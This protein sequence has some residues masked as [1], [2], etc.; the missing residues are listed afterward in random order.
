MRRDSTA[1]ILAIVGL[2]L[3]EPARGF[4]ASDSEPVVLITTG[5]HTV[6]T[7]LDYLGFAVA[8]GALVLIASN[9]V[10]LWKARRFPVLAG[11]SAADMAAATARFRI[12]P[13]ALLACAILMVTLIFASVAADLWRGLRIVAMST[14]APRDGHF[15]GLY[16][17]ASFKALI[18]L[19]LGAVALSV[20]FLFRFLVG[21]ERTRLISSRYRAGGAG[22]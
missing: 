11:A 19:V 18:G 5:C 14:H 12:L 22:G 16:C 2:I 4:C 10:N 1:S 21:I 8:L 17:M 15:F 20:G 7:L 13:N 6:F 3:G 9:V